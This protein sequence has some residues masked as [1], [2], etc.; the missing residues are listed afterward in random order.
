MEKIITIQGS[1]FHV[2]FTPIIHQK[3]IDFSTIQA[4]EV[5]ITKEII[6]K[7]KDFIVKYKLNKNSRYSEKVTLRNILFARLRKY[8]LPLG[9]IGY[10]F[11]RNHATVIHG[12]RN[13]KIMKETKDVLLNTIEKKYEEEINNIF[14]DER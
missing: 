4:R 12:I 7:L 10:F 6:E 2:V 13:Y 9:M 5:F 11:N 3:K 8:D 14:N 1:L